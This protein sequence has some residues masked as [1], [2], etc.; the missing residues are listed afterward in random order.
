MFPH[1]DVAA[2]EM[3][4]PRERSLC[5]VDAPEKEIIAVGGIDKD[6]VAPDDRGRAAQA[7]HRELPID[8]FGCAPLQRQILFV[9]NAVCV[10]TAPLRPVAGSDRSYGRHDK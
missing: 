4:L 10:R 1:L 2:A 5:S 7:R 6:A 8:V 9:A 3:F